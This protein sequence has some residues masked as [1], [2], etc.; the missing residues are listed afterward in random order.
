MF[1]FS[2]SSSISFSSSFFFLQ[3]SCFSAGL[4]APCT[5]VEVGTHASS[6]S[7]PRSPPPSFEQEEEEEEEKE[8]EE[9]IVLYART[10]RPIT[11]SRVQE[12]NSPRSQSNRVS[13]TQAIGTSIQ[14]IYGSIPAPPVEHCRYVHTPT[15]VR[16]YTTHILSL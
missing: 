11:D 3:A 16:T 10:S 8:E 4:P 14:C 12:G 15:Y 2:A 1:V 13:N 9:V 6:P 5:A 7:S